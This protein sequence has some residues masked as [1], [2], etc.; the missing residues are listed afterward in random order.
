MLRSENTRTVLLLDSLKITNFRPLSKTSDSEIL[1]V[2]C[3]LSVNFPLDFTA[4]LFGN[5]YIMNGYEFT[6]QMT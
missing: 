4:R 5:H 2:S 3:K 1:E 6:P